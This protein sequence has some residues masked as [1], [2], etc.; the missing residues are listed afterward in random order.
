M[1]YALSTGFSWI[2]LSWAVGLLS[3]TELKP[4]LAL[5]A[6]RQKEAVAG[7]NAYQAEETSLLWEARKTAIIICDMWD[8]HWCQGASA[9]VAEM[10]PVMNEVIRQA[11]KQGV[12]IV[13]APSGT[14]KFYA[15]S[16]Q[17]QWAR[18]A[19]KATPPIA[20]EGW[21]SL[22][23]ARE[24]SLPIDDSDGGCDCQ[25]K[26]PSGSPWTRQ[27]A[28]LEVAPEDAIS[29][30][31]QEIY[32]LFQQRGISH[33]MLMGVHANMC[34]LGRPFGIRQLVRLGFNVVLMRDLTD[35]MYNSRAKPF[36]SH[37]RGTD[38]IVD[39]I[40]RH[41][42]PTITSTAFTGQPAFRFKADRRPR[43][44]FLIGEQEYDAKHT[45]P[46]FAQDELAFRFGFDCV[47]LQSDQTDF[48]PGLEKLERAD[49][50]VFYLRRRT[51]PD[52]QMALIHRYLD[53][54]KPLV[55]L[56]TS[57]HAFQNWPAFDREVLG[58][59]YTGHSSNQGPNVT[60]TV[61]RMI[62]EAAKHPVLTGITPVEFR[63]TST[64][65][66]SSPLAETATPLMMGQ[67][68]G[69]Q[70][71]E[72][73]AWVNSRHGARVFY[74]SLGHPEDFKLAPF[75][76]LLLNSI[77]WTLDYAIRTDLVMVI[78]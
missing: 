42:C 46:A 56:R 38:L 73:V 70:L 39:H 75:R 44:A 57:S 27:I 10:A 1:K 3:A 76:R 58:G 23:P 72:P 15:D 35:T 43:I 22:I 60:T 65:Y 14:M 68:D 8:H 18:Q 52:S 49:L 7:H 41:W 77:L 2:T 12:L 69:R 24:G 28:A 29:D 62:S 54:G 64:L 37:F 30:S 34:V 32:N 71:P 47:V 31:G 78:K 5:H 33:V 53:A 21:C 6:R 17:R 36:V 11:R 45:L 16:P 55:A 66:S 20:L 9:R 25:P 40:E 48:L 51:L 19:P 61:V 26:C 13:H 4:A 50:A 67:I 59:H 74:T 63:V